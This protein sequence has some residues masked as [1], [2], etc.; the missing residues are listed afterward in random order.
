MSKSKDSEEEDPFEEMLREE[1]RAMKAAYES[2][3]TK[4]KQ[5]H[6]KSLQEESAKYKYLFIKITLLI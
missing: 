2:K 1:N 4:L 3:L 5:A 6:S